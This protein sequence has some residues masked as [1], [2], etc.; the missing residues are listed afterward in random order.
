MWSSSYIVCFVT[1]SCD[2]QNDI[3]RSQNS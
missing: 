2:V 1:L 3:R